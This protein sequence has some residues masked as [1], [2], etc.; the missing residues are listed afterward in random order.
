MRLIIG[1]SLIF[2]SGLLPVMSADLRPGYRTPILPAEPELPGAIVQSHNSPRVPGGNLP[3]PLAFNEARAFPYSMVGSVTFRSD[4]FT[5][6]GSA[7]LIKPTVALTAGH[8]LYDSAGGFSSA[9]RFAR[10][11]YGASAARRSSAN[12]QYLLTELY[13]DEANRNPNTNAAFSYDV[14]WLTFSTRQ[15][16]SQS[17]PYAARLAALRNSDYQVAVGYGLD[18]HNGRLPLA[19]VPS[20]GFFRVRGAYYENQTYGTE[21][22]MSGGPVF[23]TIGGKLV[24]TGV[25]VS[26]Y[27]NYQRSGIRAIDRTLAARLAQ[28]R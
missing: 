11:L 2:A 9:L 23:S 18:F 24:Q 20:R 6:S 3:Q 17:A 15:A 5:Y 4:G 7:T 16:G 12:A 14:G 1:I 26:G 8:N 27:A 13:I 28:V 25:V 10:G 22:G 21:G 19:V